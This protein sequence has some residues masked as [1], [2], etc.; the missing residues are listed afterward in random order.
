MALPVPR[1]RSQG[2]FAQALLGLLP[3]HHRSAPIL[4]QGLLFSPPHPLT[5]SPLPPALS[6]PRQRAAGI[7]CK[8]TKA[9]R[10]LEERSSQQD[11]IGSPPCSA[12]NSQVELSIK[13]DYNSN[14]QWG[15][16]GAIVKKQKTLGH[17]M[18]TILKKTW[19][20]NERAVDGTV[21]AMLE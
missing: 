16:G 8:F 20:E 13:V 12:I 14:E 19:R 5:T 7:L 9:T 15:G 3:S 11:V 6:S 2:L 4:L 21:S 17:N 1:S 10:Q 18:I